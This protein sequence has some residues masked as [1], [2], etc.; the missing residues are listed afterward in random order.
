MYKC[1]CHNVLEGDVARYHLIGTKCGNCLDDPKFTAAEDFI[2]SVS[3]DE[4]TLDGSEEKV[5]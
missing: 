1:V 3:D 4:G 5:L 2:N